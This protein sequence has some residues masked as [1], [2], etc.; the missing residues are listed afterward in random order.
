MQDVA[1]GQGLVGRGTGEGVATGSTQ[2]GERAA[3]VERSR[4]DNVCAA[5]ARWERSTERGATQT[6]YYSSPADP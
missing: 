5:Q 1:H 2:G 4:V 3:C 6:V